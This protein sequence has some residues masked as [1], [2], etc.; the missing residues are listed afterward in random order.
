MF[1]NVHFENVI[2][3]LFINSGTPRIRIAQGSKQ[4]DTT[5]LRLLAAYKLVFSN[6]RSKITL[7]QLLS[8]VTVS[9]DHK[10]KVEKLGQKAQSPAPFVLGRVLEACGRKVARMS[11]MPNATFL[12]NFLQNS[13]RSADDDTQSKLDAR[14]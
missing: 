2:I 12:P 6:C 4:N 5:K 14:S 7:S 13:L 9:Q 10:R 1:F 11:R 8:T 3:Y